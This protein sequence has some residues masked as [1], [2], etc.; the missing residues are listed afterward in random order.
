M[1]ISLVLTTIFFC[2]GS[3]I[4][5][6]AANQT[7]NPC[8]LLGPDVLPPTS[9]STSS[10]INIVTTALKK[11]LETA[12]H[13]TTAF[14]KLE[15]QYTS[16]SLDFYSIHEPSSL[17]THHYSAPGLAN[18]K[19]GVS[20]VD[21]DTVYRIGSVSKLWTVYLYLIEAGDISFNDPITK[22]VP[23]LAA[24][25]AKTKA[26]LR[27]DAIG[28]VDWEDIT[29]GSLASHLAGVPR[30]GA[31]GPAQDQV[32]AQF[33]GLPPAE[34]HNVSFCGDFVQIPC[35]RAGVFISPSTSCRNAD[36]PQ[37]SSLTTWFGIP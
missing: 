37:H 32:I 7:S 15:S 13:K 16:F 14:G 36:V 17:F 27:E 5:S 30:D 9:P 26:E 28:I 29:V 33:T 21:S 10:S 34:A 19:Q 3:Y 1:N 24:Y 11:S 20:I 25:A 35:N 31:P 18:P 4:A 22:F 23:E 8:P 2:F 6:A 12:L